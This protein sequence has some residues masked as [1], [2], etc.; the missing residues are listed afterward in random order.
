LFD[1]ARK[2]DGA[3]ITPN[4]AGKFFTLMDPPIRTALASLKAPMA[5]ER[6]VTLAERLLDA[7][8]ALINQ[9]DKLAN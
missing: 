8:S 6:S 5:V 3:P 9:L 2:T 1:F 4:M 7:R